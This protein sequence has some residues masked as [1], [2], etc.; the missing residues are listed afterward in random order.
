MMHSELLSPNFSRL[1]KEDV[2]NEV[3]RNLMATGS[4]TRTT[5]GGYMSP[6]TTCTGDFHS[7]DVKNLLLDAFRISYTNE[8]D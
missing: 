3:L 5:S 6:F 4:T 8:T 2:A 7:G 1:D